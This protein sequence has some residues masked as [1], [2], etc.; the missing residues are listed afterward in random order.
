LTTTLYVP[1]GF[2]FINTGRRNKNKNKRWAA[3]ERLLR[4]LSHSGS[5]SDKGERGRHNAGAC[6]RQRQ[7]GQ[8]ALQ[9]P[10]AAGAALQIR[11][12]SNLL[13]R[14]CPGGKSH[15]KREHC[16]RCCSTQYSKALKHNCMK[17][18]EIFLSAAQVLSR[19]SILR[20]R[21]IRIRVRFYKRYRTRFT[22]AL[23][24]FY[25][26]FQEPLLPLLCKVYTH[27]NDDV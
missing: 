16:H 25:F 13:G 18:K 1:I 23:G 11:L 7:V 22:P 5:R 10:G 17:G 12:V 14:P 8:L 15:H 24:I 27:R 2:V 6:R 26:F 20:A 19:I 3:C 21:A 4:Y 9:L